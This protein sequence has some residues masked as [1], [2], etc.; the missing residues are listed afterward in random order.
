MESAL[1]IRVVRHWL[2]VIVMFGGCPFVTNAAQESN[3]LLL[4]VSDQEVARLMEKSNYRLR[5]QLYPAKRYRFVRINYA[6]L[7]QSDSEFSI[8]PFDDLALRV[9]T[10]CI[11]PANSS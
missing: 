1:M 8:T 7:D 2:C 6:L 10:I 9:S 5:G 3:E 4:P 11:E